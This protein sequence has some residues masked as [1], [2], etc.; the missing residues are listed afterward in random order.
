MFLVLS[1]KV[2]T[3][4]EGGMLEMGVRMMTKEKEVNKAGAACSRGLPPSSPG[5]GS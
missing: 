3:V 2:K 1:L 5:S 4:V